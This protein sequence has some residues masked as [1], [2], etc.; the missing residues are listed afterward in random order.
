M[1][2]LRHFFHAVNN[3]MLTGT[4]DRKFS[5]TENW[6]GRERGTPSDSAWIVVCSNSNFSL[7]E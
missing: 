6:P 1:T 2:D 4:Y 7:Q 3:A 5:S